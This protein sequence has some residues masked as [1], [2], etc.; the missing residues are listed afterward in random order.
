MHEMALARSV[1]GMIEAEAA[2]QGFSIVR[3]MVLELGALSCVDE[4][5]LRFG[6]EANVTGTIAADAQID[7]ETAPGKARCFSC[8]AEI[9]ITER[10][11]GCPNC[12]SHQLFV[13]SGEDMLLKSLEVD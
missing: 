1:V 8:E 5:A 13:T 4:H 11:A 9:E 12:G 3:R 7:M 2:R 10:G 6:L